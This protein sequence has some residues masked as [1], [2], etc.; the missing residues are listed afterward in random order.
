MYIINIEELV[1]LFKLLQTAAAAAAV[2]TCC[3]WW[4]PEGKFKKLQGWG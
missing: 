1:R 2:W 4:M 3:W